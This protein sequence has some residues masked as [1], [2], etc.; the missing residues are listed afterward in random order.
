MKQQKTYTY[1]KYAML[2]NYTLQQKIDWS[3][4]IIEKA[5]IQGKNPSVSFSWG[6]DSIVLW[7]L[8]RKQNPN[9]KV[10][11]ADTGIEYPETYEFIKKNQEK[12][13]LK[14]NYFVAKGT[15]SFWEVVKEKGYPKPR[16]MACQGGHRTPACCAVIK[17]KPLKLKQK[18][19]G[20]DLVFWGI[21][22]TESM[23]RRL[24]FLRMGEYYFQKTEK[25]WRVAPLMIWNNKDIREYCVLN[26]LSLPK[27]YEKM[28]RN[29][30]MF[31]TAF[32]NWEKVM[33]TYNPNIYKGFKLVKDKFELKG[34]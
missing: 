16:Q 27:V 6:K 20:V 30:C 33:E 19:L 29:G 21:Q 9:V 25:V 4:K 3:N 24:L 28:E 14:E 22:A 18:E 2:K 15:K 1:E 7:N 13:G 34:L 32:R 17:E 11:F 12:F 26:S 31:C 5:L 8:I 23:N 10:I